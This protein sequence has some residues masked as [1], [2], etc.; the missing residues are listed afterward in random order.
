M[1]KA[2]FE[3]AKLLSEAFGITP[4]LYGS[5]GLE[6]LTGEDLHADDIDILIP[7][8]FLKARWNR[9][10]TLLEKHGYRLIDE[11]EHTFEKEDVS[12]SYASIEE[13]TPFAGI[14]RSDIPLYEQN[15]VRFL[16]LNLQQYRRVYA[17][18]S[19]DG[20]RADVRGKKDADKIALIDRH[21]QT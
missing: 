19:K 8:V 9:F 13:L 15:G 18:S 20:Y 7:E 2:F 16:L 3:N 6:K 14:T 12:Y 11:H 17:A 4:L 5:L 10:R 21:L 1:Q